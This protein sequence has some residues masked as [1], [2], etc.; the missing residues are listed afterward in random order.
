M[1][2]TACS[3]SPSQINVRQIP[4]CRDMLAGEKNSI[5]WSSGDIQVRD[6][7]EPLA[8][9]RSFATTGPDGTVSVTLVMSAVASDTVTLNEAVS[10]P[11]NVACTVKAPTPL[12]RRP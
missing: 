3:L 6:N 12:A 4:L 9:C 7:F 10:T 11:L 5:W 8:V 2:L 1:A